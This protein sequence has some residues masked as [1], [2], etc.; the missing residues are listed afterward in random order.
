MKK[1]YKLLLV[2]L[3]AFLVS[4]VK[5]D[6][7]ELTYSDGLLCNIAK[8]P[9]GDYLYCYL[10]IK[11]NGV[12]I[13][14]NNCKV[15]GVFNT[16]EDNEI[17]ADYNFEKYSF[18][19]DDRFIPN[20][21]YQLLKINIDCNNAEKGVIDI[22]DYPNKTNKSIFI[23]PSAI[24]KSV[25]D[26]E[27]RK[28]Y[29]NDEK[30]TFE[31]ITTKSNLENIKV[32]LAKTLSGGRKEVVLDAKKV[33]GNNYE[34]DL[35]KVLEKDDIG[36]YSIDVIEFTVDGTT[37]R[38]SGLNKDEEDNN[39]YKLGYIYS[40][41]I[42]PRVLNSIS[43]DKTEAKLNE[44]VELNLKLGTKVT[45]AQLKLKNKETGKTISSSIKDIDSNPYFTIPYSTPIGEYIIDT[46]TIKTK[47]SLSNYS[48]DF[49]FVYY[50]SK[51][52]YVK[53]EY[54]IINE[55]DHSIKI[56]K[57]DDTIKSE[58]L[59]L[60][61]GDINDEII[62]NIKKINEPIE[63]NV[64]ASDNSK[65]KKVLFESIKGTDKKLNISYNDNIWTFKGKN[66][67]NPKDIDVKIKTIDASK[68]EDISKKVKDAVIIE[69]ANNGTLP[70]K[71]NIKLY[72]DNTISKTIKNKNINIYHYD[73][74]TKKFELVDTNI[75]LNKEGYYE[76][77]LSHNSKYVITTNEIETKYLVGSSDIP[78]VLIIIIIVTILLVVGIVVLLILKKKKNKKEEVKVEEVNQEEITQEKVVNETPLVDTEEVKEE[79]NEKGE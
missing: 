23:Q 3:I 16:Q 68:N 26:T 57:D 25:K 6:A 75:K 24:I 19:I 12:A 35:S 64:D 67:S 73:E 37:Y 65:I 22:K 9:V 63:I 72:S 36:Y 66:I 43:I 2:L 28:Y 18:L 30:I 14:E 45:S 76:I 54:N 62:T 74:E 13:N 77:E 29:F 60:N 56:E 1:Y 31:M 69:F 52:A 47:Q 11:N 41:P 21:V 55:Y 70:G 20:N 32:T 40:Y 34:M 4:I 51:D 53:G 42:I 59:E 15:T 17:I 5:V 38:Y 7:Y 48:S 49:T 44:K 71:S 39:C 46:L 61:N 27:N 79:T 78:I 50:F 10:G 58:L 33:S 8:K